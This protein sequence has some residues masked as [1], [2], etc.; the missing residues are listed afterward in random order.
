LVYRLFPHTS[1][2]AVKIIHGVLLALSL[3]L[4]TIGLSAIFENHAQS[5]PPIP[6]LYTLHSWIGITAVI[7]FGLQWVCGF[8]TFLFPQLSERVR[9]AYMPRYIR[10]EM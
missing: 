6:D 1:K 4:S 9:R 2:F 7:L 10:N 3:I 8:L 5:K